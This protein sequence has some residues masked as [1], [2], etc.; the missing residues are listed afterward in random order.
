VRPE[1]GAGPDGHRTE[2]TDVRADD[3]AVLDGRVPLRTRLALQI[4]PPANRTQRDLV[5][6]HHVVADAHG[7]AN[8]DG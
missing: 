4:A 5:I 6:E 7:F 2:H 8:D 3:H 1:L